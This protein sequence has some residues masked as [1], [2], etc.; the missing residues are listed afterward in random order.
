MNLSAIKKN[1]APMGHTEQGTQSSAL[2][3]VLYV[4][5]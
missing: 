2:V 4:S 3:T 5:R 1:I